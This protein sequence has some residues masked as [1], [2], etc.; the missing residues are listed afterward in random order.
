MVFRVD[1]QGVLQEAQ[2]QVILHY[3]VQHQADI[4]L[5]MRERGSEKQ[6]NKG[7]FKTLLQN[8]FP[9]TTMFKYEEF[10]SSLNLV[11]N[12]LS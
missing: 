1:C 6:V 12:Y 9:Y 4:A 2:R 7:R 11:T 10:F 3:T 5:E 8:H